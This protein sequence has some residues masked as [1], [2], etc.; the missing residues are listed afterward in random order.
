MWNFQRYGMSV[1]HTIVDTMFRRA[2][3][4]SKVKALVLKF[5]G[6]SAATRLEHTIPIAVI[7][8]RC[9]RSLFI[10]TS[11]RIIKNH[12]LPQ[13]DRLLEDVATAFD[14]LNEEEHSAVLAFFVSNGL[15]ALLER[16]MPAPKLGPGADP[17]VPDPLVITHSPGAQSLL[18]KGPVVE[19]RKSQEDAATS[20]QQQF[21]QSSPSSSSLSI[22][23]NSSSSLSSSSS[24]G[25]KQSSQQQVTQTTVGTSQSPSLSTS[26]SAIVQPPQFQ[27][28]SEAAQSTLE[29]P[30]TV[31]SLVSPGTAAAA[32][33][34]PPTLPLSQQQQQQKSSSERAH[35]HVCSASGS[36]LASPKSQQQQQQQQYLPPAGSCSFPSLAPPHSSPPLHPTSRSGTST[37]INTITLGG[38]Q[39]F[40]KGTQLLPTAEIQVVGTKARA[41]SHSEASI[42]QPKFRTSFPSSSPPPPPPPLPLPLSQTVLQQQQQQQILSSSGGATIPSTTTT[43]TTQ[44]AGTTV[45][46]ASIISGGNV[47]GLSP[48]PLPLPLQLPQPQL[49]P[50]TGQLGGGGSPTA[51]DSG[52]DSDSKSSSDD[53]KIDQ[54]EI[55]EVVKEEL[56]HN[57]KEQND[58]K[59]NITE[60]LK[61]GSSQATPS[62]RRSLDVPSHMFYSV[63][64]TIKR[65]N[66][67]GTLSSTNTNTHKK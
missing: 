8:N 46:L 43:S 13:K 19:V 9:L 66:S 45:S 3:A 39:G 25:K 62:S 17:I 67:Q 53:I 48:P 28:T 50:P 65:E 59:K 42:T 26:A 16:E 4:L 10:T 30:D 15:D 21:G 32:T 40:F 7:W 44:V 58:L 63:P 52:D 6:S 12:D 54:R 23:S 35:K 34:T 29:H 41:G 38:T 61:G 24:P 14:S 60:Q 36:P 20:Q 37:P 22:S 18:P 64:V 27:G 49:P 56:E 11:F 55:E 47:G 5:G 31:P 57:Q 2:I 33:T 1:S 51:T